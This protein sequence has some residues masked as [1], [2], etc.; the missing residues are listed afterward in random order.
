MIIC[1]CRLMQ[2]IRALKPGDNS[3]EMTSEFCS[4]VK[5]SD[6]FD[7]W[8]YS[9]KQAGNGLWLILEEGFAGSSKKKK[10]MAAVISSFLSV[11]G[12]CTRLCSLMDL[13]LVVMQIRKPLRSYRLSDPLLTTFKQ[14]RNNW[15]TLTAG[16]AAVYS[17]QMKRME[18][19]QELIKTGY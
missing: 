2:S 3:W 14:K 7:R 11:N 15:L 4:L 9:V 5:T 12:V 16:L 6:G 13:W 8:P 17:K 10:N 18:M 19:T 1:S